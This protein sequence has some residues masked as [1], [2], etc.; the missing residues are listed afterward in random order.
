MLVV[1][2]E[3]EWGFQTVKWD[4]FIAHS[5]ADARSARKLY[6]LLTPHARVF[7]D[8]ECIRYGEYWDEALV[9]AQEDSA[10]TLILI[11]SATEKAFYQREEVAT[12]I[13]LARSREHVVVPIYLDINSTERAP[14]GLRR[15]QSAKLGNGFTLEDFVKII[16]AGHARPSEKVSVPASVPRDETQTE[17]EARLVIEAVSDFMFNGDKREFAKW[18]LRE[19]RPN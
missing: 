9:Q 1:D 7:L 8:S 15:V 17:R 13:E 4:F 14:Y 3:Q 10:V 18:Y 11:S 12:A 2:F 16:I 19:R 5:S 6:D